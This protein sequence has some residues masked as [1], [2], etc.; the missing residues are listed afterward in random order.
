MKSDLKRT[1]KAFDQYVNKKIG[2]I[3]RENYSSKFERSLQ[4]RIDIKFANATNEA[5]KQKI[6]QRMVA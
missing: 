3:I 2:L 1:F 5:G 4:T 6:V